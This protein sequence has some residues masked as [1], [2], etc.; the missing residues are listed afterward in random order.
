MKT[1][2]IYLLWA[3]PTLL[4]MAF[5]ATFL[6]AMWKVKIPDYAMNV[7]VILV[8]VMLHYFKFRRN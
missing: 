1:A 3:I 5:F 4:L 6:E 7:A 2:A 8:L